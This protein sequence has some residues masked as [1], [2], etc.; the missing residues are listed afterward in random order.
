VHNIQIE[1]TGDNKV[2]AINK[3]EQSYPYSFAQKLYIHNMGA[4]EATNVIVQVKPEV[5]IQN[6]SSPSLIQE[7]KIEDLFGELYFNYSE[8]LFVADNQVIDIANFPTKIITVAVDKDGYCRNVLP[9]VKIKFNHISHNGN[10]RIYLS[11]AHNLAGVSK[12]ISGVA[13]GYQRRISYDSIPA[14]ER[15]PFWYRFFLRKDLTGEKDP[16]IFNLLIKGD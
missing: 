2:T 8:L 5:S 1:D 10:S 7:A 13:A 3:G 6:F 11:E 14:G 9:N 15:T 16:H 12:D 4:E